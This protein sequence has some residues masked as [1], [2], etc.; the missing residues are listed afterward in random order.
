MYSFRSSNPRRLASFWAELMDLPVTDTGA[1][2]LVMLDFDHHVGPVTWM[3]ERRPD[4]GRPTGAVGLDVAIDDDEGWAVLADR[5]EKLGAT[6][7]GQF[8]QD[9]ARWIDMRDPD[10]NRFRV[11]APRPA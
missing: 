5:A 2:D 8:E 4:C 10:G 1:G 3:F 7:L 9:G 6:R 11:F